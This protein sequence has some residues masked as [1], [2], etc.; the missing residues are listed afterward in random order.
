MRQFADGAELTAGEI[1]ERARAEAVGCFA[2]TSVGCAGR[3][4]DFAPPP[5][6]DVRGWSVV[7]PVLGQGLRYEGRSACGCGCGCGCGE[8][9]R[10][11]PRTRAE[12]RA[13]Q[14][15]AARD[16]L[17]LAETLSGRPL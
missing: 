8:E 10:Y 15:V 11:R 1:G 7:A 6:R 9:H 3:A 5:R 4:H 2:T 17:P 16:G 12:L 13:R 14:I